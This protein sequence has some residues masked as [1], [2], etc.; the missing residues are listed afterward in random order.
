MDVAAILEARADCLADVGQQA[1]A[2]HGV[3]GS[4]TSAPAMR[5]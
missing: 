3:L 5:P 1:V 2:V 4:S